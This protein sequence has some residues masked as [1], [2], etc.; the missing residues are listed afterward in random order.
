MKKVSPSDARQGKEGKPVLVVLLVSL[1]AA[2][3]VWIGVEIFG[4]AIEP[5]VPSNS[6]RSVPPT[7]SEQ[8]PPASAE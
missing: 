3:L 1:A 5:E 7:I 6:E 4:N 8:V 2:A